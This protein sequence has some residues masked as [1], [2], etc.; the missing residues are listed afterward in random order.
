MITNYLRTAWR[1]LRKNKGFFALNFFGLYI[2]VTACVLI[3]LLIFYESG[4]DRST[5]TGG[6]R[7]YR[8]VSQVTNEK[9]TTFEAVTPY[10][11]AAALRTRLPEGGRV[12]QISC[13][14][15]TSVL[16]GDQVLKETKV[17]F[18]DSVFPKL[19]PLA[20]KAGSLARA[21]AEPGFCVL[22][23]ST[24]RRYFGN[25]GRGGREGGEGF[26]AV[27]GKRIKVGGKL[28]LEVAAVVG[29]APGNTHL[30]YHLLISYR[31]FTADFIGGF[32]IDQW[33]LTASG[34]TYVAL[35]SPQDVAP[36]ESILAGLI[37][38]HLDKED[39][40]STHYLLQSIRAIHYDTRFA[41][42]NPGYTISPN[43]LYLVGAIGLFLM[44]A[45]CINY[46]NLSTALA[47][48]Q[49]KEVGIR[50][51]LGATRRQLIR[52]LLTE[53]LL[54]TGIAIVATALSVRFFLPLMNGFLEKQIPLDWLNWT[55]GGFLLAL[56]VVVSLL[57]GVYPAFV[58][59]G[60][61]PVTALKS[62]VF[63]P[64][65]SVLNLRRGLVVFQ[66]VT[67]QILIIGAIVVARQMAYIREAPMGF[68]KDLVVDIALPNNH[69]KEMKAFRSRLGDVAGIAE[70]SF[71][72][73]APISNN[74]V[75][76]GFNLREQF[77]T[78]EYDVA[79]KPADERYLSTYGLQLVAGRW[80]DA[81][82]ER[83]V[84]GDGPDSLKKYTLVLNETAT[85][86]LGFRRPEDAIGRYVRIGI[87]EI[88]A[89]VVGVVKDYHVASMH[90]AIMP[91]VMVPFPY[92]YYTVGM[93][94]R[95]G[96]SSA[97]L[98]EVGKAF[99]AVYP[100]ELFETSF[101]DE[102]VAAQ[103]AEERRTQALFELFMGMSIAI[104]VLGLI[105]LLSFM[106]E[107]KTKE[108]GIRKVLGASIGDISML[109]SKDFLRLS[110]LAF[111][112]AAPVA[113]LLMHRWL[114]D[115]AYR[116]S[117]AWWVFAGALLATLLVTA[118]AI[119]FQT[120]RAAVRNP[121][122]ALRSE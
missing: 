22:P 120:L 27:I 65:A 17:V 121:V 12:A 77:P 88:S 99:K 19:W 109:L 49:S 119:S 35:L 3:A 70:V 73:S 91:V 118:A 56:W 93:R 60:F 69:P 1:R 33:S 87:N 47:I 100:H 79:V 90:D 82:D 108:V 92:L 4:F 48:R 104:N 111:L 103:Y 81:T 76:T 46:T 97:T 42:S 102:A 66:F 67:A 31:S 51:T 29:D 72:I 5:A 36:T 101:L 15:E 94:L 110:G 37:Q 95:N 7:I 84:E 20:V 23:E 24:A 68:N 9:G 39:R 38:E 80:F 53:S 64:G 45:A 59:S 75:G 58:L 105:G 106:I 107:S 74:H 25:P 10:P 89:P 55:S 83:A 52:Q 41:S 34:Y 32:N 8:V 2:S 57:A 115:F 61:R 112:I 14:R 28:D 21:F 96:Y 98:A 114:Q 54:L 18:A 44:L 113:G 71:S 26:D 13:D 11:L 43:Y 63:T 50:K 40:R 62:K 116:A 85:R 117:L 78:K 86:K 30:P 6:A 16:I 122:K